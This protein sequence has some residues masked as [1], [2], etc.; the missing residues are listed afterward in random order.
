M[1]KILYLLF[2]A[3]ATLAS[4]DDGPIEE[5]SKGYTDGTTAKVEGVLNGIDSW[6]SKYN[7]AIAGFESNDK[8]AVISKI[9]TNSSIDERGHF[10]VSLSG[11]PEN[12]ETLELCVINRLRQRVITLYSENI[13][14]AA[15]SINIDAG[16]FDAEMYN[17]IQTHLFDVSCTACHGGSTF[18]AAGLNLTT[19]KSYDGLVDKPSKKAEGLYLVAP[20]DVT[21]SV[22][23]LVLNTDISADWRQNHADMLNKERTAELLTMIDDWIDYEAIK[24]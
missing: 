10:S 14:Q 13:S 2:L 5:T 8:Y 1:K 7:I 15:G 3:L 11:I 23:H 19:G 18:S 20:G 12:V 24:N 22:L 9:I 17:M 21:N 4:C 6:P 16:E